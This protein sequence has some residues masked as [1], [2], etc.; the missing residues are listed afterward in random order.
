VSARSRRSA[1]GTALLLAALPARGVAQAP[2]IWQADVQIQA[3]DLSQLDQSLV[4]R[5]VVYSDNHDE[6]RAVHVEIL[7]PLGVGVTR[8]A[9]GC[10]ASLSPPGVSELRA[11]V[12]CDMGT[13]PVR[14][15]REVF[16]ITTLPAA[17]IPKTFGVFVSS[18]TPDPRPGNNFAE[19]TLP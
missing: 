4:A 6:A 5:V 16:V 17:G 19:K 18:D 8:T 7:L 13:L 9:M 2:R 15:S 12:M 14:T 1:L 10:S 3:L 11:R